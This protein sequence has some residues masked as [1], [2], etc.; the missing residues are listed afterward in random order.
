MNIIAR[1]CNHTTGADSE[2]FHRGFKMSLWGHRFDK[3][4]LV[5]KQPEQT[6]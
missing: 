6:V 1:L 4:M 5:N 3:K 2:L